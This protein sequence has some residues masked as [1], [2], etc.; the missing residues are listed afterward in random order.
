MKILAKFFQQKQHSIL[1]ALIIVVGLF[2][3]A[4]VS[5]KS[6]FAQFCGTG[7]LA[8]KGFCKSS[9]DSANGEFGSPEAVCPVYA[10]QCCFNKKAGETKSCNAKCH[11]DQCICPAGCVNE[12]A[13]V[14]RDSVCGTK[15]KS[16]P[17]AAGGTGATGTDIFGKIESPQGVDQFT[18]ADG[19]NGL[20]NFI[21][22]L[23]KIFTV[24]C[25]LLTFFN[26]IFSGY[27]FIMS[28]GN[29]KSVETVRNRLTYSIL[30]LVLIVSSYTIIALVSL[31][32]FGNAGY[33]LNP[34]ITPPGA[35]P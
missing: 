32:I 10:S 29:A 26:F 2:G 33:I 24:I 4:L 35:T 20:L 5:P 31:I 25:G 9:C 14:G 7:D 13:I 34:T 15:L 30:G 18:P 8:G 22:M 3:V 23:I 19:S 12:G 11:L 6:A 17:P 1:F 21:S 27:A 28:D 16:A